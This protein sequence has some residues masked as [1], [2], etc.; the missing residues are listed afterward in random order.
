MEEK[1]GTTVDV[2][3]GA[4][5]RSGI[6]CQN[7]GMANGRCRLHGGM[8]TGPKTPEGRER[9][10]RAHWK[11][12]R[13]SAQAREEHR[14]FRR[15]LRLATELSKVAYEEDSEKSITP[16]ELDAM[17]NQFREV[18]SKLLSFVGRFQYLR[19]RDQLALHKYC[20]VQSWKIYRFCYPRIR[21]QQ[22]T[23]IHPEDP[24]ASKTTP[25]GD[26]QA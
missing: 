17:L 11:H 8:S 13:Y 26:N 23:D 15:L 7:W 14:E 12:G 5:I 1:N 22:N 25:D 18:E 6:P 19:F 9:I 4:K 16:S 2:L 10:R 24:S 21:F 3:C 20:L